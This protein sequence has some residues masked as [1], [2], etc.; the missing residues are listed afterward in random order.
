M[1][2]GL[3]CGARQLVELP[4]S[5]CFDYHEIV[6]NFRITEE[7]FIELSTVSH[8]GLGMTPSQVPFAEEGQ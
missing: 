1:N 7:L 4:K 2:I 3:M 8:R 5:T 6:I